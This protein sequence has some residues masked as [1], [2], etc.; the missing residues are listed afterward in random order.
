MKKLLFIALSFSFFALN[1]DAQVARNVN[2]AQKVQS[3]STHK[4]RPD[5]EGS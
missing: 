4:R 5:D 2:S 1:A 3:D